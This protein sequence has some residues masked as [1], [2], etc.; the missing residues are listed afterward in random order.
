MAGATGPWNVSVDGTCLDPSQRGGNAHSC[1]GMWLLPSDGTIE[2]TAFVDTTVM[3]SFWMG[4]RVAF[5]SGVSYDEQSGGMV[6]LAQTS[7]ERVVVESVRVWE[8]GSCW[9]NET[10]ALAML[11]ARG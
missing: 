2:L 9:V 11:D 7:G 5:T 6:V 10:A 8:L 3:E 1:D 4:G